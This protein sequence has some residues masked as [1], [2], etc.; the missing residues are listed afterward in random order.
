[1]EYF[2]DSTIKSPDYEMLRYDKNTGELLRVERCGDIYYSI[3][4]DLMNNIDFKDSGYV[5][6]RKKTFMNYHK[7]T[8][9]QLKLI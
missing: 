6:I 1:M 3:S 5:N 7:M 8:Y 4:N 9:K 2:K